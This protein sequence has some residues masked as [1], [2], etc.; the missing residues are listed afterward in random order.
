MWLSG[1]RDGEGWAKGLV[2]RV[3]RHFMWFPHR[4]QYPLIKEY[5]LNYI[6]LQLYSVIK[7][8]WAL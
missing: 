6:G 3:Y 7:G 5:G 2:F 8:Y 4:A 1:L